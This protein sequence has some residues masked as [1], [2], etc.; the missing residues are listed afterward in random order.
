MRICSSCGRENAQAQ[1]FCACGEYLRWERTQGVP[2]TASRP[3]HVAIQRSQE[4]NQAGPGRAQLTIA[5]TAAIAPRAPDSPAPSGVQIHLNPPDQDAGSDESIAVSVTPGQRVTVVGVIRNESAIVDNYELAVRGAPADWWT[6][7]PGTAYLVPFGADGTYEQEFTVT[8]HPPRRPEATAKVWPLEIVAESRAHGREVADAAM[9]MSVEPY[10]DIAAKLRPDRAAGRLRARFALTLRN[11]GNTPVRL[12]LE[13][14]D[15]DEECRFEFVEP[16]VS[17]GAGRGLESP[18]RVFPRR[19]IWIGRAKER[20][21]LITATPRA[22]QSARSPLSATYRQRAWLPWWLSALVPL[23]AAAIAAIVLLTPKQTVVPDLRHATT[24]FAAEKLTLA[25][26]L[27]LSPD[28]KSVVTTGVRAG[29]IVDQVPAAGTKVKRGSPVAIQVAVGTGLATVPDL[30]GETTGHADIT[31][32]GK[33]LAL[34]EVSP[35]PPDPNAPIVSQIPEAGS[36]VAD[37]TPVTVFTQ[38]TASNAHGTASHQGSAAHGGSGKPAGAGGVPVP[39]IAG[40]EVGYAE[41][42]AQLGFTPQIVRRFGPQ[43]AGQLV[44]TDPAAGTALPPASVVKLVVSAGSPA[45]SY[46]TATDGIRVVNSATGAAAGAAPP[47]GG[48]Q[49]ATW[50][51]DASEIVYVSGSPHQGQLMLFRLN[52]PG[53]TPTPL[54]AS[55]LDERDPAISPNGKVLAFIDRTHGAGRLCLAVLSQVQI[56]KPSCV[57]YSGYDLGREISWSR[58]GKAIVVFGAATGDPTRYGLIEFQTTTPFAASVRAWDTGQPITDPKQGA[59]YGT[60]SPDGSRIAVVASLGQLEFHV[61]LTTPGTFDPGRATELAIEGCEVTWRSD[62]QALAVMT[63]SGGC[64]AMGN[65][66]YPSG[67][68]STLTISDPDHVTVVASAAA[69]PAWQP[70]AIGS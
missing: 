21:L 7:T 39:A 63:S 19:Q 57:G 60:F 54:T 51:P 1:D 38:Q 36:S 20:S 37:G 33:G 17:I 26:G 45:L 4:L 14:K 8:L 59:I 30:K 62:G 53:A 70:L 49:E 31:L 61:F 69:N 2:A 28:V 56:A 32:G 12:A 44:G 46:D 11:R 16:N 64:G 40:T 13:G 58:S 55:G 66:T 68:I 65:G 9:T 27:Q 35:Q 18:V 22:S 48:N 52:Q 23:A 43:P 34:G 25:A 42:L 67:F 50:S 29:S 47:G 15:A 41:Q 24:V 10:E 5:P 6:I 3:E